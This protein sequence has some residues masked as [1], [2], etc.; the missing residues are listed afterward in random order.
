M[1]GLQ[2][3]RNYFPSSARAQQ[4]VI[5]AASV[6]PVIAMTNNNMHLKMIE[7]KLQ[8][9]GLQTVDAKIAVHEAKQRAL[10]GLFKTLLHQLMT[11]Q[12]RVNRLNVDTS[13]VKA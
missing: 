12:I 8:D 11:A 2:L 7:T 10:Q 9:E 6:A 3:T 4:A 5:A 1:D 13:E